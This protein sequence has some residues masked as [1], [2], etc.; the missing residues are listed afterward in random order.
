MRSCE[1]RS[2]HGSSSCVAFFPRA[3][4]ASNLN[5]QQNRQR[6]SDSTARDMSHGGHQ[7]FY[8][9][10]IVIH[11]RHERANAQEDLQKRH[12][13]HRFGMSGQI[14]MFGKLMHH[15]SAHHQ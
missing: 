10:R 3:N 11:A 14:G 2:H 5:G 6:Q 13:H 9:F 12:A 15:E 7:H 4:L 8:G 1:S